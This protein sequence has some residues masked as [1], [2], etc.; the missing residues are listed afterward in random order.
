MNES[1]ENGY[2]LCSR[3][4][5]LIVSCRYPNYYLLCNKKLLDELV[6]EMFTH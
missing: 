2:L 4:I 5:C 1:N 3:D 6:N